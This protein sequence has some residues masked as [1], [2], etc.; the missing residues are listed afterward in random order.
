MGKGKG[1]RKEVRDEEREEEKE[2]LKM[3]GVGD[4]DRGGGRWVTLRSFCVGFFK[5][6]RYKHFQGAL[7][8]NRRKRRTEGKAGIRGREWKEIKENYYRCGWK[9]RR[10]EGRRQRGRTENRR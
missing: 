4:R 1:K 2:T 5:E 9:T 7:Q 3:M 6:F 10:K 8:E